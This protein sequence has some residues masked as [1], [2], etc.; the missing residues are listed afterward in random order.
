MSAPNSAGGFRE[1]LERVRHLRELIL[2]GGALFPES[3]F[4]SLL[5]NLDI[6]DGFLLCPDLLQRDGPNGLA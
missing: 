1:K 4:D 3:I 2:L 5:H 6:L